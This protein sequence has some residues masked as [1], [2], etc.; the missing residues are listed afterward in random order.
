MA[1]HGYLHQ[2][3]GPY[4]PQKKARPISEIGT[5]FDWA[6]IRT[7]VFGERLPAVAGV[8]LVRIPAVMCAPMPV[9]AVW[10]G[11]GMEKH[12]ET[13]LL[14]V[15]ESVIERLGRICNLLMSACPFGREQMPSFAYVIY[16]TRSLHAAWFESATRTNRICPNIDFTVRSTIAVR[17]PAQRLAGCAQTH[18]QKFF[19]G[20]GGLAEMFRVKHFV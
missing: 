2:E 10:L 9:L 16:L 11:D 18:E 20:W 14:G 5:L 7:A 17:R 4:A 19:P 1:G 3:I 12:A 15:I 13:E 6:L 8:T